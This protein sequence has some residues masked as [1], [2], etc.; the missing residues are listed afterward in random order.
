MPPADENAL[1]GQAQRGD[2]SAFDALVRRYDR[3]VLRLA[4]GIVG[5]QE[6]A[7][8]IYQEAFLKVFRS[9][10]A[11]RHE[12]A[13]RTWLHRIVSN[14]C[15][16]HLR[17]AASRPEDAASGGAAGGAG[18]EDPLERLA[19]GRPD[20]DPERSVASRETRRRIREALARLSPRER[21]VFE[22]RHDQGLRLR[23]IGDVLETSEETARNCLYRAHRELRAA[24]GDLWRAEGST[25]RRRAGATEAET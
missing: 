22:L 20:H 15:L 7:R 13:F 21:L 14:L 2:R 16:D 17:R 24:L 12:C 3:E 9:L 5:S 11:F 1:I 6:E 10:A 8:D 19:D 4:L 23:A 25:A 18:L